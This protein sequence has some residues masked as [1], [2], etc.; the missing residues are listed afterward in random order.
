M[1]QTQSALWTPRAGFDAGATRSLAA[2]LDAP[3]AIADAL[4]RRGVRDPEAASAFL[5]PS[6][7][8]LHDPLALRDMDRA[9]ARVNRALAA[10]ERILVQGDYDVD[11]I[12][13]TFLLVSVL[14]SLGGQAAPRIP[15]RTRDGYG[16]T[17]AAVDAAQRAGV[18]LIVTVDCGI[19][20]NEPIDHARSLGIDVVVTD[21]H[22][23][24]PTLPNAEAV[25]NPIRPGCEYP[26]K[27]L[28]GVGVTF[29]LV[30][31]LFEARGRAEAAFEAL[32]LVALG[33]IA[34][35]VPLI[36]ENRILA[37]HGLASLAATTRPGL[38][39]LMRVAGVDGRRLTDV[40]VAFMLAPRINAAGRMGHADQAL[41]LLFARDEVEGRR[42]AEV[43]ERE[44]Q[45]R[46]KFDESAAR[47]ASERVVSQLGWPG[48][49]SLV[50]WDEHWHPGVV[51]IVAS[52]LV[53]RFQRP[54]LLVALDGDLGRG[55]AR[56]TGGI[57]LT[58]ILAGCD[59]LLA[60]WGGHA[61]AAG[62]TLRRDQL[63]PFRTRVES[64]VAAR[65][66]PEACV[67]RV[68]HDA[69]LTLAECSLEL[70]EW[71]DRMAPFG[72]ANPEPHFLIRGVTIDQLGRV[73]DGRHLKLQ[74]RD[75][76]AA[77]E[78][79]GF[80]LGETAAG[81][82]RGARVDLVAVPTRNEWNGT[83]RLQLRVRALRPA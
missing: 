74:I 52:R 49:A 15:H 66:D 44:N 10:N 22:E 61:A 24:G 26:F 83:T 19:T 76:A 8:A 50:L 27:S 46:R 58:E 2:A 71:I 20:A 25:V 1:V 68:D 38:R 78:A 39:E 21:H 14:R 32:D 62:F 67:P 31:A 64:L 73:G 6:L 33:T 5:S 9:L 57:D 72:L 29:K 28:A 41:E 48:P 4:V 36:G 3:L 60:T 17:V 18:Q 34:D 40:H 54:A 7:D 11:G 70:I 53:E 56:T 47:E 42:L 23:P 69:E 75:G 80:G 82:A 12:T 43:L 30:Q 35:V 59:D 45:K 77:L 79:I 65:L 13:S 51:G 37:R 81:I 63:V 16:L 55:S